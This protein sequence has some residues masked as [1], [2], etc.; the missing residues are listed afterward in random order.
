MRI[1]F[2]FLKSN[3]VDISK[4]ILR[5]ISKK[6]SGVETVMRFA[7]FSEDLPAIAAEEAEDSDFVAVFA[8]LEEDEEAQF[9]KRKLVDAELATKTRILKW[10]EA[11][12]LPARNSQD[13]LEAKEKIVAELVDTIVNILFK[14]S[15]FAPKDKEFY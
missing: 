15:S 2:V 8:L 11:D 5:A 1:S 14:E 3:E 10:V 12:S 6:I 13:F 4:E 7:P 9:I